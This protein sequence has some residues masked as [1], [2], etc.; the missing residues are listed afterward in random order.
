MPPPKL[1]AATLRWLFATSWAPRAK[2]KSWAMQVP[3]ALVPGKETAANLLEIAIWNLREQGLAE[4]RQLRPVKKERVITLGGKSFAGVTFPDSAAELPGVEGAFLEAARDRREAK[5]L[6]ALDDKIAKLISADDE[7]SLRGRIYDLG[8]SSTQPW[9]SVAAY[10][11]DEAEAAGVIEVSGRIR[12]KI[13]VD[14]EALEE[15]RPRD[16]EIAEARKAYRDREP[17]LDQA[18]FTDCLQAIE[19]R[20]TG[21]PD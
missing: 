10:C 14:K 13:S 20:H 12:K 18:V 5:G 17:D 9:A 4:V 6:G 15:L 3:G 8:L 16:T 7:D 19:W 21:S 1:T 2:S 11:R